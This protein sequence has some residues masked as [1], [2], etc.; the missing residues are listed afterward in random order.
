MGRSGGTADE[1]S[2]DIAEDDMSLITAETEA[3]LH[4]KNLK[5]VG[6]NDGGKTALITHSVGSPTLQLSREFIGIVGNDGDIRSAVSASVAG[7]MFDGSMTSIDDQLQWS[8]RNQSIAE[9]Q[10]FVD[11]AASVPKPRASSSPLRPRGNSIEKQNDLLSSASGAV[12]LATAISTFRVGSAASRRVG[13]ASGSGV[14]RHSKPNSAASNGALNTNA[15]LPSLSAYGL[16]VN[17]NRMP[18]LGTART[19]SRASTAADNMF[20]NKKN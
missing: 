4:D 20:R 18:L 15:S 7:K 8:P 2:D 1:F 12:P 19:H 5:A 9:L 16:S 13:S 17:Q 3:L 11:G 6:R 10:Q 14:N